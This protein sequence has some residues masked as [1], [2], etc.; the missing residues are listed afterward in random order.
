MAAS[1]GHISTPFVVGP[2]N[3]VSQSI[4]TIDP[5]QGGEA[6]YPFNV[7]TAGTY[8][9]MATVNCPTDSSNSFFVNIDAEPTTE[10]VWPVT[11]TSGLEAR[12]VTYGT[13]WPASWNLTTGPH[14]LIIRGREA[15]AKV[16]D[17]TITPAL[18]GASNLHVVTSP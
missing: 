3:A 4:Q 2:D 12:T 9:I 8:V 5:A 17:F 16:S 1:G 7:T 14:Q 6:V 10:M 13:A 15:G 11:L 18:V